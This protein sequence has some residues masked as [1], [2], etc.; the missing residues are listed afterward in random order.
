MKGIVRLDERRR[1]HPEGPSE[2]F[3]PGILRNG[4]IQ[5][6]NGFP[7]SIHQHNVAEG[8][9]LGRCFAGR[10]I[11]TSGCSITELP[12]P[13]EGSFFDDGFGEMHPY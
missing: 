2:G 8:I 1:R 10:D 4:S 7:K 9:P 3:F 13:F 5:L 12:K 6:P 11:G